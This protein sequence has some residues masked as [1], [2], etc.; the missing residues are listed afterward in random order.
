MT[1]ELTRW[2]TGMPI[3][4]A[5]IFL[6]TFFFLGLQWRMNFMWGLSLGATDILA[7]AGFLLSI[8]WVP[9]ILT[10]N[11]REARIMMLLMY[12]AFGAILLMLS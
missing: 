1:R 7:G 10:D 6:V 3:V 11:P 2:E 5:V 9:F 12:L 8:G 4:L